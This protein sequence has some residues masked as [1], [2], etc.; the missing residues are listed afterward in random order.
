MPPEHREK[1]LALYCFEV[2]LS[3]LKQIPVHAHFSQHVDEKEHPFFVTWH[4]TGPNNELELRGCLGTFTPLPLRAGLAKFALSSA[5][6]DRRF[7]RIQLTEVTSLACSVSIL[8][9]FTL[10]RGPF[11]WTIGE[12]GISVRCDI[13]GAQYTATYLPD[14]A[15]SQG[16]DHYQTIL[17]LLKKSG[18][19]GTVDRTLLDS[20]R[21]TRYHSVKVS[22]N[23][24]DYHRYRQGILHQIQVNLL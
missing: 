23:Y 18:Y 6:E 8:T 21:V 1:M 2:L 5:F 24:Q 20:I 7:D 9:N 19:H 22:A 12:H 4:K 16:W 11:D 10:A 3:D 14:V 15:V 17:S 13:S